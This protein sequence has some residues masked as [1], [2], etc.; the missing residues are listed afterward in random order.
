MLILFLQ[1]VVRQERAPANTQ[2]MLEQAALFCELSLP[3]TNAPWGPWATLHL[4]YNMGDP[5]QWQKTSWETNN[6]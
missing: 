1:V 3:S 5:P 6:N 2:T 4:R